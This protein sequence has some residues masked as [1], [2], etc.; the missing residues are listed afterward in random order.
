MLSFG[1]AKDDLDQIDWDKF[2]GGSSMYK[3]IYILDIIEEL[4]EAGNAT[5]DSKRVSFV[6]MQIKQRA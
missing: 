6:E 1:E 3:Q 2:F 4:M 5:G